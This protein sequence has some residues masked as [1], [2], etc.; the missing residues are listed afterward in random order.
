M[1]ARDLMMIKTRTQLRAAATDRQRVRVRGV[2]AQRGGGHYGG[3]YR[4][5]W[6]TVES[7]SG[8]LRV[9]ASPGTPLGTM[10][11]G[12]RI[13]LAVSLTGMVNLAEDVYIGERAQVLA[14]NFAVARGAGA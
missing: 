3:G 10:P 1:P 5:V 13:E 12:S 2:V 9:T 4:N 8:N 11:V 14:S 7:P 6:L